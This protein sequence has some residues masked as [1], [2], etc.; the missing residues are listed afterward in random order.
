MA[1]R[2]SGHFFWTSNITLSPNCR[3]PVY[4]GIDEREY[5]NEISAGFKLK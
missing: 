2:N 3:E 1:G 4:R 5:N